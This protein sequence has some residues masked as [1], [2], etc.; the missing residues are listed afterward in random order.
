MSL[1]K[2]FDSDKAST[3]AL[4]GRDIAILEAVKTSRAGVCTADVLAMIEKEINKEIRLA[5]VYNT[6]LDL[7]AKGLIKT[8]GSS[9]SDNGGR[10]RRLFSITPT[11][12]LA[13]SLGEKMASAHFNAAYA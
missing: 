1:L 4:N 11:G 2:L 12:E 10:P 9:S 7:E 6:I 5:T 8:S 3:I 13:L